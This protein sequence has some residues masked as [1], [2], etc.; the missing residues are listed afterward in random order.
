[1]INPPE[2]HLKKMYP[3]RGYYFVMREDAPLRRDL[4]SNSYLPEPER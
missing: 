4:P 3:L 1:M 2:A